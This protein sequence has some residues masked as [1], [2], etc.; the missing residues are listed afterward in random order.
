MQ[1]VK[2][3]EATGL[4]ILVD[5]MLKVRMSNC[6]CYAAM[7]AREGPYNRHTIGELRGKVSLEVVERDVAGELVADHEEVRSRY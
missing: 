3:F 1:V 7:A 4:A 2:R 6:S 5:G